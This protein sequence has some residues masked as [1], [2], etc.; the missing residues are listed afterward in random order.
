MLK[1]FL[2]DVRVRLAAVFAGMPQDWLNGMNDAQYREYIPTAGRWISPDPAGMV[3]VNLADPK[4]LNRYAYV[5]NNPTTLTD[6]LV[7]LAGLK[8][9]KMIK[10]QAAI[11]CTSM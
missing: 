1:Q 2:I 10:F 11:N 3:A 9:H 7:R 5:M 4:S 6:S 8:V